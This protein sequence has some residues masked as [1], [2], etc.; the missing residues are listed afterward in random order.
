M[1]W[2]LLELKNYLEIFQIKGAIVCGIKENINYHN[3]EK[4]LVDL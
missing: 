1:F 2:S 3:T 4:D